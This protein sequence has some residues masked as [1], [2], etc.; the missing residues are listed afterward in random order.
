MMDSI[1]TKCRERLGE[2]GSHETILFLESASQR[3]LDF[4][5]AALRTEP[6]ANGTQLELH[7]G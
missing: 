3:W 4:T 1:E 2:S 6:S 5:A 7:C